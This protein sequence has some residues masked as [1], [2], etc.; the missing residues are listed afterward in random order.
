MSLQTVLIIIGCIVVALIYVATRVTSRKS[1][2][3]DKASFD[4]TV[5]EVEFVS[6][7]EEDSLAYESQMQSQLDLELS[8][9]PQ[10]GLFESFEGDSQSLLDPEDL[11]DE[12]KVIETLP[13]ADLEILKLFLKPRLGEVFQGMDILRTLN[14]V[15]MEFGEMGIFHKTIENDNKSVE[16]LFSA[17][18]MFEPGSFD[19]KKIE[20]ENCRGLVFF[21]ELPT[22]VD[23]GIA[24]E[25]LV[26][27]TE[28]VAKL[29]DGVIYKTPDEL[30]DT[31]FLDALRLK[32]N[33]IIDND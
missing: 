17:A 27:T 31:D 22:A 11:I 15:G 14:H 3:K 21:M 13:Q 16:T 2:A 25:T 24:L 32:T 5:E 8:E 20:S 19:L 1:I 10:L 6:G 4:E 7:S 28:R 9:D 29:L 26:T 30:L 33:F 23:D 18:N 12:G